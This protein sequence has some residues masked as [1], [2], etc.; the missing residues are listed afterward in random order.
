MF[1]LR[2]DLAGIFGNIAREKLSIEAVTAP[3]AVDVR[4][5]AI[6]NPQ[7]HALDRVCCW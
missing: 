7:V 3:S 2:S 6:A 4:A 5:T 1:H